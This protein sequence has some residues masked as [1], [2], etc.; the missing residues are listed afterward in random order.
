MRKYREI[1]QK[2]LL[3]LSEKNKEI[4]LFGYS[5]L[6]SFLLILPPPDPFLIYAIFINTKKWVRYT[7]LFILASVLG[8]LLSYIFGYFFFEFFKDWLLGFQYVAVEFDK[9]KEMFNQNSFWAI[10]LAGLTPI[11]YTIFTI[12]AGVF[13]TNLF[14]FLIASILGRGLRF[15]IVGFISFVLGKR[16]ADLFIKYFDLI[17]IIIILAIVLYLLL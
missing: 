2:K 1:I 14:V 15:F 5:F 11:P 6:E 3:G 4:F 13:K 7:L 10:F 17:A 12:M 16:F 8:G 9:A